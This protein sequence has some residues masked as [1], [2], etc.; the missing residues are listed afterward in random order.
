M[1]KKVLIPL[2][3]IIIGAILI[4]AL[5]F[6]FTPPKE[7]SKEEEETPP[8]EEPPIVGARKAIVLC[9]ANDFYGSSNDDFN[10]GND[11][12]FTLSMGNWIPHF[13]TETLSRNSGPGKNT[14]GYLLIEFTSVSV[15]ANF[16]Y[17][18]D[19]HR[20]LEEYTY[21]N[22]SAWIRIQGADAISG[23]ARIGLQWM[24]SS[25]SVVRIDWSSYVKTVTNWIFVNITGVC[26][27]ETNNEI[28]D[29]N[30]VLAANGV[31]QP[32]GSYQVSFDDLQVNKW[33][34]VNNTNPTTPPP[35]P[36]PPQGARD[37]DGFPAQALQ[38]Y[39]ILKDNGYTDNNIYLMLYHT[40]DLSIDITTKDGANNDLTNAVIDVENDLV[41]ASR[42][43]RELNASISGSFAAGIKSDDQLI[44]YM[45][46]HGSNKQ[47]GD[48]N[49]SFCFEADNSFI[50]ELEFYNLVKNIN[51]KRM[52]INIDCCFSGN[53]LNRNS[54]IA[55]SWYDIKNSILISASANVFSW[56]W[57]SNANG[58]GFAGS[59]FFHPFWDQLGQNKTI[60]QAFNFALNFSPWK[61]NGVVFG[62]QQPLMQD[63]LG[64]KN[65]WS[66]KGNPQL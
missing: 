60:S 55:Q 3:G 59:W 29:L 14:P 11:A 52:L 10:N 9:S 6:V 5:V 30:L 57:I 23:G 28:T 42:F 41:N 48:G 58:D 4:T 33:I 64:I 12:N 2:V 66:L 8:D 61:H 21:Y 27:N 26:N 36:P 25:G 63:N 54:T 51:C 40:G 20:K 35:P 56:Y 15:D 16:T 65:I 22:L 1:K 62:I 24:N 50:R 53:F 19:L 13:T 31:F 46:D 17:D 7:K 38:V 34:S 39:W 18:W 47:I 49:A 43:K 45:V 32:A 44:I 37:S